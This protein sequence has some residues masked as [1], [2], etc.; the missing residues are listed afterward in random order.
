MRDALYFKDR[1]AFEKWLE[2]NHDTGEGTD[3]YIYKKGHEEEGITY[4]EAVRSA[5]CYGWIDA[6]THSCDEKRFYQYFAPRLKTSNWSLSN[7]IRMRDLIKEGQ[8]TPAGTRFFDMKWLDSLDEEIEA[9]KRAKVSEIELPDFFDE[10]LGENGARQLF[11]EVA[12]SQR[13]NYIRY[14]L[15]GKKEETRL[16]RCHKVVSI[17]KGESKNNL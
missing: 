1:M 12:K 5:L 2:L 9:E 15:D 10:I 17:I 13:R 7:K 4:E 16:R 11:D 8:M 14:I 6:V 3:I